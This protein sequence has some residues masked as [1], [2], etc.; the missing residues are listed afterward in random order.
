[1]C[2]RRT[3]GVACGKEGGRELSSVL[4]A[5]KSCNIPHKLMSASETN[6]IIPQLN[7]PEDYICVQEEDGG[8]IHARSAIKVLQVHVYYVFI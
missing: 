3:G 7:I 6:R 5:V 4:R 2:C 1:M 8:I